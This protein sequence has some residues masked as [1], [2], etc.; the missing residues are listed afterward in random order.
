LESQSPMTRRAKKRVLL[1]GAGRRI[2]NN[3]LPVLNCLSGDFEIAGVHSRTPARLADVARRWNVEAFERLEDAPWASIDVVAI[4]TPTSQNGPVLRAVSQ[5]KKAVDIVIDTP[6]ASTTEELLAVGAVADAFQS[7]TIAEDYMNFPQFRLLREAVSLGL[8]G[9]PSHFALFNIGYLYH[10]LALMRSF[11]GFAPVKSSWRQ[12]M[13]VA[14]TLVGYSFDD[15]L[16]A[17]VIPPYRRHAA[18]GFVLD[19][20]N[21]AITDFLHD[22]DASEARRK[23]ILSKRFE[24]GVLAGFELRGAEHHLSIDLPM[25]EQQ[26]KLPFED[27]SDL[28]LCRGCG[29]ADVFR[30]LSEPRSINHA[31]GV[32]NALY[33]SFVSRRAVSGETPL[34]QY[35]PARI[36]STVT[37]VAKEPT[38]VKRSA[39]AAARLGP[40]EKREVVPGTDL[41]GRLELLDN[42]HCVITDAEL[43]GAPLAGGEWFIF[44]PAWQ[45][46]ALA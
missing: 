36:G 15:G 42:G 37:W 39:T 9:K 12:P 4:S 6:L 19:G 16:S 27:K 18:G 45:E 34:D 46:R 13:G 43:E 7:V 22:L 35:T 29:L 41:K 28:N 38:F 21:G 24:S 26:R 17:T 40:D 31:Y 32:K 5:Q 14:G 11:V 2:Q 1:I 23:Y 30:S 33:D 44:R 3:F 10:G 25:L 8:I 20:A